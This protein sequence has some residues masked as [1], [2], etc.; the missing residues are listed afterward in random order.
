VQVLAE[1]GLATACAPLVKFLTVALIRPSV[2]RDT[3]LTI[4][5]K[6]GLTGYV[7]SKAF[8]SFRH[9]IILY[10]DLPGLRLTT[11]SSRDDSAMLDITMNVRDVVSDS[12][13]NRMDQAK[14]QGVVC[15]PKTIHERLS[16]VIVSHLLLSFQVMTDDD[17]S[18]VYHKWA[19]RP[20]GVSER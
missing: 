3:P 12:S 7:P 15:M 18:P 10:R 9:N 17:L 8:L 13:L 2:T 16:N 4:Q 1:A 20:R 19:A 6:A 14:A 11:S 5:V